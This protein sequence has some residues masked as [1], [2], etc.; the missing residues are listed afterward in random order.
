M[1]QARRWIALAAACI[2]IAVAMFISTHIVRGQSEDRSASVYNP[3]PPGILPSNLS[4]EV[5]RVLR[6][7]DVIE[8]RA[9]AR[10]HALE[11]PIVA[12]QPPIL[13]NEGTEGTETLGE[14]ML[15]DKN[16]SPNKNQACASCHMPY[17]GFS[18]PIPSVN[19]T[20]V[21]FPGTVH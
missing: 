7:V 14:L 10:W 13:Q 16:I 8:D 6:E 11:P 18:G 1:K 3:Y 12:G 17:A 4:S 19:L 2:T 9:L 20:M 5:A 15:F 21:A